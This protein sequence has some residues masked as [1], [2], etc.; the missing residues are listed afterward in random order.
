MG[1]LDC[2]DRNAVI[3]ENFGNL[4]RSQVAAMKDSLGIYGTSFVDF[5]NLDISPGEC[6]RRFN[7]GSCAV[8]PVNRG[9]ARVLCCRPLERQKRR[10]VRGVVIVKVS[11]EDVGYGSE[12]QSS[13]NGRFE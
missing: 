9:F 2:L 8:W 12:S 13:L 10:N 1:V 3:L 5:A 11:D 4:R 7:H 6:N